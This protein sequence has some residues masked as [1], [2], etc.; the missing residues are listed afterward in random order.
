[1]NANVGVA[2]ALGS[3]GPEVTVGP[4]GAVVSTVQVV[5]AGALSFRAASVA[6]TENVCEPSASGPIDSGLV[7]AAYAEPSRLHWKVAPTSDANV[8]DGL[9]TLLGSVGPPIVGVT[10]AVR[11]I[12]QVYDAGVGST[13]P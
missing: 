4:P 2:V 12:V 5:L 13:F 9:A 11:S 10:G 8:I 1:M 3:D 7:H 6:F